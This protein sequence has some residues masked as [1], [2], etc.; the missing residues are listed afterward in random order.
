M[1]MVFGISTFFPVARLV[2]SSL[3]PPIGFA[4]VYILEAPYTITI[5]PKVAING[6]T[7]KNETTEPFINPI[8]I[9]TITA[10]TIAAIIGRL[11]RFLYIL[12]A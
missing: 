6:G 9:P 2:K 5:V 10:A 7:F 4:F 3:N 1:K 8:I 11:G 12:S